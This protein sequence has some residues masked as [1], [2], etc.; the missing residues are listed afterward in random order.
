MYAQIYIRPD[1]EF[2]IRMLGRYEINSGIEHC[3]ANKKALRY[4]QGTK[5]VSC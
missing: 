1:I 2:T 4:M 5:M 3:K